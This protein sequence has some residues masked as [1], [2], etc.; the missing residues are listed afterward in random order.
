MKSDRV[1]QLAAQGEIPGLRFG[2]R[3][4]WRFEGLTPA[5]RRPGPAYDRSTCRSCG[6][7]A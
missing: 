1:R 6:R 3:G 2:R 7:L 5:D 4:F